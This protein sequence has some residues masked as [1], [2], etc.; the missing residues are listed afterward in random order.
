MSLIA[1]Q[2]QKHSMCELLRG[3]SAP[4]LVGLALQEWPEQIMKMKANMHRMIHWCLAY[5]MTLHHWCLSREVDPQLVNVW[6]LV[7]HSTVHR[8]CFLSQPESMMNAK[9]WIYL[10][11]F[12]LANA[13]VLLKDQPLTLPEFYFALQVLKQQLHH[14]ADSPPWNTSTFPRHM[15]NVENP[16]GCRHSFH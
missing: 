14:Q 5:L 9:W 15:L 1:K 12:C 11:T 3:Y 8:W 7:K 6:S 10:A 16:T 4:I 13:A 2:V